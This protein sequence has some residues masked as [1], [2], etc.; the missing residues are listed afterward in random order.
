MFPIAEIREQISTI[1]RTFD[2]STFD[3]ESWEVLA[4]RGSLTASRYAGR[5]HDLSRCAGSDAGREK[6]QARGTDAVSTTT[7]SLG[8]TKSS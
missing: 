4:G 1:R 7:L 8:G 6:V 5:I 3:V 2:L